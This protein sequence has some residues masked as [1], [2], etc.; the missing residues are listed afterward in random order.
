MHGPASANYDID[1]GPYMIT[2]YYYDTA[3]RLT[4]RAELVSNGAPPKSDNILFGGKNIRP[5]GSGGQYDKLTLTPGK[6]HLL[7]LINTSVDNSLT[8]SLVGHSFTVIANDLVP[9]TPTV[10]SSLFMG[11]GQRYDVII[12]ANQKVDNYWLN[13]T[14]ESSG[15]CGTTLNPYPA[16]IVHYDGASAG[17]PTNRGT[18]LTAGCSGETGFAP[19]LKRSIPPSQF[20]PTEL[21]VS[22]TFPTTQDGQVFRWVV[23]KTPIVV[24]WDH[25]V[26]EYVAQGNTSYP[27]AGNTVEIPGSNAW[28][29]WV[30]QNG[31][32]LPH[33]VH[34][35]GHD[36]LLLGVGNGVFDASHT[37]EL[38]FDNPVRRDVAQM[39]GSGWIVIAFK[40][41]N[42]GCWLLHCHIGWHVSQGLGI[43]FLER[44]AEIQK[45]MHL[46]QIEPTC[47]AW[48]AY[49]K[50]AVWLPKLDSGLR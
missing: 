35:H 17:T 10:R 18:P 12:E 43:Q 4:R 41:D 32:S 8:I 5:T 38:Q 24:Q 30:V 49:Q 31:F 34:L 47:D 26:L 27:A 29:F 13:A 21:D 39:P 14:L 37:H 44:K 1:L 40:T 23:N 15:L 46:D 33:P 48:R 42:P 9:I 16:A 45:L 36:F 28:T 3:D 11:V 20:Q 6:K 7:R 2:D 50:K 19:V 25:P 22:L